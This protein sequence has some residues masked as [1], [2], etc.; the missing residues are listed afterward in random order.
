MTATYTDEDEQEHTVSHTFMVLA[1]GEEQPAFEA[2]PSAEVSPS[3]TPSPTPT[4]TATPAAREAMPSTEEGVPEP[5]NLTPTF[6]VFIV[7][8]ILILTGFVVKI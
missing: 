3:P 1:A 4:P 7:G 8:L 5:G 2:T 6:F